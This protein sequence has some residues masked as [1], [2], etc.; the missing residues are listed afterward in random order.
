MAFTASY[1]SRIELQV[2]LGNDQTMPEKAISQSIR[3]S[4]AAGIGPLY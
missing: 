4:P 2:I 1:R 3:T